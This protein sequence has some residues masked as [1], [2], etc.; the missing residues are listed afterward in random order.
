M[1]TARYLMEDPREARRLAEKVDAEAWVATYLRP[2]L[3]DAPRV[4]DVGCG[5]AAIATRLA[6]AVPHARVV[7]LDTSTER[8]R[9]ARESLSTVVNGEVVRGDA[10][11]L[12]FLDGS[13]DLVY[14]RFLLEYLPDPARAVVEAARVCR[15]GGTVVLQDVDGQLLQHHPP[16]PT[17]QRQLDTAVA[18]LA[19]TGF[20]PFV[21]RKLFALARAAGMSVRDL[22]V[23]PYHLIAGQADQDTRRLWAL[24]LDIAQP[25][26]ARAL[27]SRQ[28][29]D[30]LRNR[31]L[32][33]LDR[34]D[35]LTWS[36]LFTVWASPATRRHQRTAS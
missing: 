21:G 18:G 12:P 19:T 33:Y 25:A 1:T 20:D 2:Y 13:F 31:L 29:A 9:A 15:A 5:P 28:E 16:D 11:A 27:G 23:E 32:A 6:A 10:T 30:A 22:R 8:V 14:I 35:T 7:G 26:A 17:L 24:K 4:L 34:E 3:P 36:Y